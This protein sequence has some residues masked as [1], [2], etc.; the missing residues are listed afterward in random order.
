MIK[1]VTIVLMAS[2]LLTGCNKDH[3][4]E[5]QEQRSNERLLMCKHLGNLAN[6]VLI[7]ADSDREN[8]TALL[9]NMPYDTNEH[10][11][12]RDE[13]YEFD[14]RQNEQAYLQKINDSDKDEL[15]REQDVFMAKTL[16]EMKTNYP[17][18]LKFFTKEDLNP[19]E[20]WSHDPL[21]INPVEEENAVIDDCMKN[22]DWE[23]PVK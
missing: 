21:V 2:A 9:A 17:I 15:T 7:N 19:N 11:K 3:I 1:F 10:K 14:Y 20:P 6:D 13:Q 8:I 23:P 16:Y 12:V 22:P 4:F 18:G 5:S